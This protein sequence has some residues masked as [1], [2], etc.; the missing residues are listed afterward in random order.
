VVATGE[1]C[2]TKVFASV[3][4]SGEKKK[5]TK[6]VCTRIN[7]SRNIIIKFS[8]RQKKVIGRWCHTDTVIAGLPLHSINNDITL[9]LH[10]KN[11]RRQLD[12]A[13]TDR[14]RYWCSYIFII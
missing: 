2:R 3:P 4:N 6:N 14:T 7:Y 1:K 13:N 11:I 5:E 10:A 8:E 12:S 9:K